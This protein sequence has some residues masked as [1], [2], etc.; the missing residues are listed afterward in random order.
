MVHHSK[1]YYTKLSMKIINSFRQLDTF[2]LI[3]CIDDLYREQLY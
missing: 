2:Y 3:T 1:I